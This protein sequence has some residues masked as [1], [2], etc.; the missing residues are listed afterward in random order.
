LEGN[1]VALAT[2]AVLFAATVDLVLS[3]MD[4]DIDNMLLALARLAAGDNGSIATFVFVFVS[5]WDYVYVCVCVVCS[6]CNL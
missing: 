4:L 3:T 6:K 2:A 1:V 5:V